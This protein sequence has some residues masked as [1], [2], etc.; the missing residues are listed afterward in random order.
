M[1][2]LRFGVASSVTILP[3]S[4]SVAMR[5]LPPGGS[6]KESPRRCHGY[7]V[8]PPLSHHR[9]VNRVILSAAIAESNPEG[10]SSGYREDRI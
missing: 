6:L 4:P 3:H 9:A 7:P 2:T 5:Q 8:I 1:N 10:V